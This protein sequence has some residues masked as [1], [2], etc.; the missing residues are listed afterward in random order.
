[1]KDAID[2]LLQKH[3]G[4]KDMM[5]KVVDQEYANMVHWSAADPNSLLHPTT[6]LHI[7]CYVKHWQSFLT[8]VRL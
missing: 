7:S 8:P 5:M 1:M 2:S 3:H 4:E 6:R